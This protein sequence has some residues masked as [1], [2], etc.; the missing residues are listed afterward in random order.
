MSAQTQ[1]LLERPI[2][3]ALLSVSDKSGLLD[4]ARALVAHGVE[5]L[6]TGGT[7]IALKEAGIVTKDVAEHTGFPE[8]MDGRLKTLH[9][10]VHGGLLAR[11]DSAAHQQAAATHGIGMIDL[12]IVNLYPFASAV[13]RSAWAEM[14]RVKP[15]RSNTSRTAG[16]SAHRPKAMPARSAIRVASRNTRRP[17][18]ETYSSAAQSTITAAGACAPAIAR[19]SCA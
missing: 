14:M 16:C 18:L 9:P 11:R 6:S 1:S 12:L 4:L 3:R 17:A 15:L 13:A 19:S 8:M 10:K 2:A 7:A 5:I